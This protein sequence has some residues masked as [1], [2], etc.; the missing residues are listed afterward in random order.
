MY[1]CMYG[2]M[3]GCMDGWMDGWMDVCMYVCIYVC[4]YVC[5]YVY[6]YTYPI[7]LLFYLIR[8]PLIWACPMPET[9][10]IEIPAILWPNFGDGVGF[11]Q[12]H[13]CRKISHPMPP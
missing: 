1:V 4:M 9:V 5:M 7:S 12:C 13:H 11:I 2:W 8:S 3:D 6:V 10:L